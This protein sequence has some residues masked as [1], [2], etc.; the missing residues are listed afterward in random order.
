MAGWPLCWESTGLLVSVGEHLQSQSDCG[1]GRWPELS[2]GRQGRL[3]FC[4]LWQKKKK[5]IGRD[6]YIFYKFKRL[7][8][9]YKLGKRES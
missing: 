4:G 5:V 6:I 7:G 9:F 2:G 8:R 1:D 3:K